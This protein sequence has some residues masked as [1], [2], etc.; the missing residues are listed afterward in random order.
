MNGLLSAFVD[1][2]FSIGG[3]HTPPKH[4]NEYYIKDLSDGFEV[5]NE[6]YSR[7]KPLITICFH[8]GVEY[9]SAMNLA[10]NHLETSS[11][12]RERVIK[13]LDM[14]E[15][16]KARWIRR[17]IVEWKVEPWCYEEVEF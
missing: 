5:R 12:T 9:Y 17:S 10:A 14:V 2:G 13:L 7:D 15:E 6:Y 4:K 3:L 16:N 1:A 11:E 8:N